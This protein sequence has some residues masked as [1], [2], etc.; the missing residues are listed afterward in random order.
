MCFIC[1]LPQPYRE[2][3]QECGR[4]GWNIEEQKK[5]QHMI[6]DN[7]LTVCKNGLKKLIIKRKVSE[8]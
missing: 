1:T 6:A 5:R 7:K 3:K 2:C 4:C 8:E